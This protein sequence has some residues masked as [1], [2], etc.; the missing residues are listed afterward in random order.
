MPQSERVTVEQ[1][2]HE[3]AVRQA[4]AEHEAGAE[5]ARLE[6]ASA[7]DRERSAG[8]AAQARER[9]ATEAANVAAGGSTE[10]K[11]S[12]ATEK[13]K[14]ER[15][16]EMAVKVPVAAGIAGGSALERVYGKLFK[17]VVDKGWEK[18]QSGWQWLDVWD[19]SGSKER[20][21][22]NKKK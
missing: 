6:G 18:I 10:G 22:S 20:A 14:L 12:V 13:G 11:K 2:Q 17:P 5:Q 15:G 4:R 21:K 9:A 19:L 7:S 8:Q 3:A 16:A 1:L